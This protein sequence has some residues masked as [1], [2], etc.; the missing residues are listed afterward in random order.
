VND[1]KKDIERTFL[2]RFLQLTRQ[3]VRVI[4]TE[5]PDFI[6]V[7]DAGR[8]GIELTQVARRADGNGTPMSR[9]E[10]APHRSIAAL[11]RE[12]YAAGGLPLMLEMSSPIPS[13]GH[14]RAALAQRLVAARAGMQVNEAFRLLVDDEHARDALHL[15][16]LPESFGEFSRWNHVG[17][18]VDPAHTIDSALL[19]A[20]VLRKARHLPYYRR[21]LSDVQLLLVADRLHGSARWKP[22]HDFARLPKHGFDAVHLLLHPSE[23]HTVG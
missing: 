7:S 18:P 12:Y 23:V 13:E 9:G 20:A 5:R 8:T 3:S 2:Q 10:P 15:R 16:A 19:E 4:D 17:D 14:E 1:L 11:A 21:G 22:P 6:L